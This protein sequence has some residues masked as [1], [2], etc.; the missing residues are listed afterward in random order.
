MNT[1]LKVTDSFVD[2]MSKMSE[3][4]PGAMYVIRQIYEKH[5]DNVIS[6]FLHLD[7]MGI[8]GSKIWVGYKDYCKQV[9]DAFCGLALLRDEDMKEFI[10]KE[11]G[12]LSE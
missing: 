8:R 7:S 9:L 1:V 2:I 11:M 3:G 5:P 6:I 12:I 10:N 4:N